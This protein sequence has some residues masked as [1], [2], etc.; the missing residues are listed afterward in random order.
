M[1]VGHDWGAR[2][3]YAVAA[4]WPE[5]PQGPVACSVGDGTS[6]PKD[7]I[8]YDQARAYWYQWYFGLERGRVA[9]EQDPRGLCRWL[10]EAWSPDWH[11]DDT[12][13]ETTARSFD[14]P[15]FGRYRFTPTAT[16]GEMRPE[17]VGTTRSKPA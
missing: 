5:R 11:L 9:L 12:T 7:R 13:F 4:S 10:W 2:A 6:T 8:S 17:T 16:A 14:N 3:A 1:L 15:H